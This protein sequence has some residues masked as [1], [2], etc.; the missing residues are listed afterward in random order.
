M[1]VA[2]KTLGCRLN[3]AESQNLMEEI[4]SC[5]INLVDFKNQADL[6]IINSCSVTNLADFKSRQAVHFIRNKH[7]KAK[8]WATGCAK[9]LV[10]EADLFFEDKEEIPKKILE[11]INNQLNFQTR[12][13]LSSKHDR[14][15]M[16]TLKSELKWENESLFRTRAFVKIQEGCD[17]F[18]AYCIV[19]YLRGEPK[20]MPACEIIKKINQKVN[21][22]YKEVVLT[23]VN[24]GKYTSKIPNSKIQIPN[25][26]QIPNSK[27]QNINLFG[28]LKLILK[29]TKI[30]RIRLG[31]INPEDINGE[32]INLFQNLRMCRHLHLSL[33]SGSNNV[34][35]RMDRKYNTKRYEKIV[36]EFYQKYPD[37]NFTTDVI[38][39][40]PGETEKEFL[41]T[42]NFI[43][44][45]GLSKV[46]IF[47]YSKRNNTYAARMKNQI[48]EK[49]KLGRAKKL[50]ILNK[51][52]KKNFIK[53]MQGKYER[54]L[55][56]N[57]KRG[58]WLGFTKN[59]LRV[60]M[61]SSK[62]LK[63]KIISIRLSKNNL[64]VI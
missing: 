36:R 6:Y 35:A 30:P 40:F 55:F 22:G 12:R 20:S 45:I 31:S 49:I 1:K 21:K 37:F 47:R 33:Q 57:K 15:K 34:L 42:Y 23:G 39:G 61:E 16:T 54:V 7:L 50:E 13:V 26:F 43:K 58:F 29:N 44:K 2:I 25:K 24:I 5:G 64:L 63:N 18:C 60:R 8:I 27:I 28:L 3:Q 14:S 4:E 11:E 17:N 53:K 59:Y 56:E 52:L 9:S 48:A 38:V 32:F 46:H 19:P 62:D 41:Q 51:V 10:R